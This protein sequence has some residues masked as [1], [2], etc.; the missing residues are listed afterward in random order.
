MR[1]D[2]W[3]QHNI[4]FVDREIAR[5][6]IA[7][8]LGPA[9]IK[10]EADGQLTDWWFMNKQPWP[11]RYLADKPSPAI[12]SLLSDLIGDG[13]VMSCLLC[14]YEPETDAFGGPE[15]MEAAH[16]SSTATPAT[17]SPTSRAR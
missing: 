9:L 5:R 2:R 17:C 11:L 12:E 13:V 7:E 6:T 4:T 8:R 14:V 16:D 3:Q 10:A 15:A 1:P